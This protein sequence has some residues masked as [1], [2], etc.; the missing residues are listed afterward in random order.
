MV[1]T[2]YRTACDCGVGYMPVKASVAAAKAMAANASAS[3]RAI[4]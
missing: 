2:D 1:A 3:N 4:A